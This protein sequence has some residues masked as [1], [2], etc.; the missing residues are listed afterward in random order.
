[1]ANGANGNT[2]AE[3]VASVGVLPSQAGDCVDERLLR[4]IARRL[5]IT[6]PAVEDE[7]IVRSVAPPR[8]LTAV[9]QPLDA[10]SGVPIGAPRTFD[11]ALG[12]WTDQVDV[13]AVQARVCLRP[14][15]NLLDVDEDGCVGLAQD[16]VPTIETNANQLLED[17]GGNVWLVDRKKISEF[18][19]SP[20]DCN[21][22]EKDAGGRGFVR[23]A[24]ITLAAP[25]AS[26]TNGIRIADLPGNVET[27]DLSTIPEFDA[28]CHRY[29][30][31]WARVMIKTGDGFSGG[32]VANPAISVMAGLGLEQ[33]V[34]QIDSDASEG[35]DT[36]TSIV[37]LD[38]SAP[39]LL[40]YQIR[41]RAGSTVDWSND[42]NE[43]ALYVKGFVA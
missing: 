10:E 35:S 27:F 21:V 31:I 14:G 32:T 34:T 13:A 42:K 8:D 38:P 20:D 6:V 25:F 43:V 3:R 16:Q 41:Q 17:V 4:E 24:R 7:T 37:S 40:P 36:N 18:D 28:R 29:A 26:P 15:V 23:D 33:I 11:A 2:T 9:W 22:L 39:H 12:E 30:I 1:M 5:Q 19:V